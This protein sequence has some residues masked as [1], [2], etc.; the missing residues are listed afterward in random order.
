M[1]SL[2]DFYNSL[3]R[4]EKSFFSEACRGDPP[5]VSGIDYS[6]CNPLEISSIASN[7][8]FN[9][10]YETA[11]KLLN[12]GFKFAKKKEDVAQ[13]HIGHATN[14]E[15]LKDIAKCNYHCEEA[16]RLFHFGTYSYKRLIINYVKA[17]D[18]ES[19]LRICD[20]A[21]YRINKSKQLEKEN[22]PNIGY[23]GTSLN[24]GDFDLY[25]ERRKEFILKKIKEE[26]Q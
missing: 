6:K 13:F 26:E 10:H 24:W 5:I 22:K 15:K 20:I 18:W 8:R 14:Y 17:K 12:Y 4:E 23:I 7:L 25:L 21:L 1:I 2:V 11:I 16:V 9:K 3:N 19:A